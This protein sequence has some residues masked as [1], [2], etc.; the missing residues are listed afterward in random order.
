MSAPV[1]VFD[2]SCGD[3]DRAEMEFPIVGGVASPSPREGADAGVGEDGLAEAVVAGLSA[4]T[5]EL[6]DGVLDACGE[7][8]G[9]SSRE[10]RW[11]ARQEVLQ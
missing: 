8:R 9:P 1:S 2:G 10:R 4:A 6:G 5:R 7:L 11:P 3:F